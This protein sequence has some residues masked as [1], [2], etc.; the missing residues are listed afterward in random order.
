MLS[1]LEVCKITM[2]FTHEFERALEHF[3]NSLFWT[4]ILEPIILYSLIENI[5]DI[6]SR[7]ID[8]EVYASLWD[9][10]IWKS[11]VNLF[12]VYHM[13]FLNSR[14][15]YTCKI[16]IIH[17]KSNLTS[18]KLNFSIHST[19]CIAQY[20]ILLSYTLMKRTRNSTSN[21]WLNVTIAKCWGIY[22]GFQIIYGEEKPHM[23]RFHNKAR[24][25]APKAKCLHQWILKQN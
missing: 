2:M 22:Y 14:G 6:Q 10:T 23:S 18:Q 5:F 16:P 1:S 25:N 11:V 24:I 9:I 19:L 7:A 15:S 12:Y 8:S 20:G 13:F 4:N 21:A 17:E 3:L